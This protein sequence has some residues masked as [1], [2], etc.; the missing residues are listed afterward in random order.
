MVIVICSPQNN[1]STPTNLR[2]LYFIILNIRDLFS[3]YYYVLNE[4]EKNK[5]NMQRNINYILYKKYKFI[6]NIPIA[7]RHTEDVNFT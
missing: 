5:N 4:E 6:I 2:E 7:C 1:C 3:K